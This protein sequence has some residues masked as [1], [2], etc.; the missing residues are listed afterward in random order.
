[1]H[2]RQ[3]VAD[4]SGLRLSRNMSPVPGFLELGCRVPGAYAPGYEH[5]AASRLRAPRHAVTGRGWCLPNAE[6][7]L[8]LT[9]WQSCPESPDGNGLV[10]ILFDSGMCR[11]DACTTTR[12]RQRSELRRHPKE[13]VMSHAPVVV[14]RD[15]RRPSARVQGRFCGVA[16]SAAL[17]NDQYWG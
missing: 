16:V 2:R 4:G 7:K 17:L 8:I 5:V 14:H 11:R 1:M 12:R 10:S 13:N 9:L 15:G 6:A 3:R